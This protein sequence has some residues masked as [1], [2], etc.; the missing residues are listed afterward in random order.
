[1]S[2]R[3]WWIEDYVPMCPGCCPAESLARSGDGNAHKCVRCGALTARWAY[4]RVMIRSDK[5]PAFERALD[6]EYKMLPGRD[7]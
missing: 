5:D 7:L 2:Q 4:R 6:G 3:V 1:M